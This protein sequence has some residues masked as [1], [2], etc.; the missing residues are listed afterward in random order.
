LLQRWKDCHEVN[1]TLH[2]SAGKYGDDDDA[3]RSRLVQ[4]FED[5]AFSAKGAS[6]VAS[7]LALL[8][9]QS[10][11]QRN[12]DCFEFLTDVEKDIEVEIK[13]TDID[14]SALA[15]L[16]GDILF[17]DILRDPKIRYE[18]NGQDYTY[19]RRLDDQMLGREF[20]L[21]V[22][23]I[24][25]EHANHG[26]LTVLAAQNTGKPELLAI[27]PAD[28]RVV[29]EARLHLKTA[30]FIQ[31]NT[32]AATDEVRRSILTQ[33]GLQNSTRRST[34]QSLCADLLGKAP[35]YLNGGR[36][37]DIGEGD[38]R[39]RLAKGCQALVS[40]AYPNLRMLKGSY[41]EALLSKTL[42]DADDLLA[43]GGQALSEAEQEVLTYVMRNYKHWVRQEAAAKAKASGGAGAGEGGAAA[44]G[45]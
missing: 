20:D 38:P 39:N 41:D 28:D 43:G 23:V 21:S 37:I 5:R 3:Y 18:G 1:G 32:G 35:L 25:T 40:F 17:A 19:T 44:A 11:L 7:A 33:R 24:T 31:Q 4:A 26:E 22:N 16:L 15:K 27:L 14:E 30:K 10:Y 6:E 36:L 8:A 29:Q 12:G 45:K 2:E 13:N 34:I 42:L 9:A